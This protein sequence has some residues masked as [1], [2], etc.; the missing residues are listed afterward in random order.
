MKVNWINSKHKQ[1]D[2]FSVL[3]LMI[4]YVL[5]I[6]SISVKIPSLCFTMMDKNVIW[7]KHIFIISFGMGVLKYMIKKYL[8]Q[9]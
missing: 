3:K 2:C 4:W 6:R 1:Q 7:I 8:S 5:K 9:S